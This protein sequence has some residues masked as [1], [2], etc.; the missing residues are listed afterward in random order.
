MSSEHQNYCHYHLK[1]FE[2]PG[3]PIDRRFFLNGRLVTTIIINPMR[4]IMIF[5]CID[6]TAIDLC[7]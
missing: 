4:F 7:R 1:E 3:I 5:G 2:G 6:I